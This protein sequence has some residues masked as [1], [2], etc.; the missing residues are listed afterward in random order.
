[1]LRPAG[2]D[3]TIICSY[4]DHHL[5]LYQITA[6]IRNAES[7]AASETIAHTAALA[8]VVSNVNGLLALRPRIKS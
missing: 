2:Y 5:Q 3:W 6:L 7:R 4:F 8:A 1:M